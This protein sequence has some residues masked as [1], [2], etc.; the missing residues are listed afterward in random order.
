[1]IS[2]GFEIQSGDIIFLAREKTKDAFV[3]SNEDRIIFNISENPKIDVYGDA[4]TG[5]HEIK[6]DD[7]VDAIGYTLHFSESKYNGRSYADF[8]DAE[9]IFTYQDKTNISIRPLSILSFILFSVQEALKKIFDSFFS[10]KQKKISIIDTKLIKKSVKTDRISQKKLDLSLFPFQKAFVFTKGD[11]YYL[12]FMGKNDIIENN[13]KNAELHIQTTLG[14]HIKDVIKVILILMDQLSQYYLL[15]INQSERHYVYK[16]R[17]IIRECNTD[18]IFTDITFLKNQR[19]MKVMDSCVY[20]VFLLMVYIIKTKNTRKHRPIIIRHTV[21]DLYTFLDE[22]EKDILMNIL[23][24]KYTEKTDDI[25]VK[26]YLNHVISL[27][28]LHDQGEI[29][30]YQDYTLITTFPITKKTILFEFRYFNYLLS[31][32]AGIP[33]STLTFQEIMNIKQEQQ[34]Q[35]QQQQEPPIKKTRKTK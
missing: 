3:S 2:I 14:V 32:I 26:N 11:N 31:G 12:Y 13:M 4:P 25:S 9:F 24:D 28:S 35:E 33:K 21:Y 18:D 29:Y 5:D 17:Q 8:L 22:Y 23:V 16:F 10:D 30:K 20:N 6:T 15:Y 7:A 19:K 1:M 34:Q 27:H